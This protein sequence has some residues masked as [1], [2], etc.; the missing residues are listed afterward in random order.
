MTM[1]GVDLLGLTRALVDIDSTTGRETEAGHWL[2]RQLTALGFSVTEQPVDGSRFNIFAT[3][4]QRPQVVLS[5]H[6][7][8]VPP[9]LPSRVEGG[10]IYGRG[11]CDAK[12][13]LAAQVAAADRL[14][15]AGEHRVALLFVVGEERGS[16]GARAANLQAPDGIRFLVDGEPTDNRLALATRGAFR[17]KLKASG[18]A[19]H[20]SFPELGESAIDKLLDALIELRSIPLPSDDVLGSTH[21]T[22]GFIGGGV[23]SNVVSPAAEA[24]VMF[25]IVG[26]A[27][28]VRRAMA[29]L[30]RLVA[31][32]ALVD[33]PTVTLATVPGFDT[34]VFPFT[35]DI[36]YLGRWGRPLLYG[37]GSIHVAHTAGEFVELAGLESAVEGYVAIVSALLH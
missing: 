19:A 31:I 27:A 26:S 17:V 11:A 8:C 25:R 28:E 35:T 10:R 16:D 4:S 13:I 32:E 29:P 37:P 14:R 24:E 36:P 6:F 18:R 9:F 20:S 7:D 1:P 34:A 33:V 5:T 15:H 21:Y 23:A 22:I 30:E 2:S 3:S 12:G